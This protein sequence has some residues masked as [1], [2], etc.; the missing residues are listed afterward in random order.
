MFTK[1]I[2]LFT[3]A[4]LWGQAL[5]AQADFEKKIQKQLI[6]AKDG[7]TIS[8]PAGNFTL[9]GSLS[10]ESKKNITIKGKGMGK[11]ILSFKNQTEGAEG[12]RVSNASNIT[13]QDLTVQDS[14]GDAIKTMNVKGITF[15]NVKTEWTGEV[16]ETNGAYGLYPVSCEGVLIEGCE[17]RGA[18]DAGIYVGQSKNIIVRKSKA[19]EN[20]AGIEIENS[21]YADVYENESFN[22]TGGVLV[23]DLPDLVQKKGGNVRVYK[24]IIKE[25]NHRNFAPKGNIVASVPPGT[26]L[27]IMATSQVEVFENQI[28]NNITGQTS[29]VSYLINQLPIKDEKYYPYPTAIFIHDNIYQRNKTMPTQESPMGMVLGQI[30]GE[31]VPDILFDGIIDPNTLGADGKMKPELQICIRNNKNASFGF[32]DAGGG[33]QNFNK[34]M[35]KYDCEHNSLKATVLEKK[36]TK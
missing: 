35:S 19:Y 20:V 29:I 8:L 17:A 10:L 9:Q 12:I 28:I 4:L 6:L 14:K 27:M 26:G 30:F 11:T 33:F 24:N 18:S 2:L 16:K 1:K 32:L 36:K 22:N 34:D 7:A 25:N 23:F 3:L 21:L 5:L 15:R 31:N 13:I